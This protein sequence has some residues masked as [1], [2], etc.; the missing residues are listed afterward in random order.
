MNCCS[1]RNWAGRSENGSSFIRFR[2]A[3]KLQTLPTCL[4]RHLSW[5]QL[6]EFVS[7]STCLLWWSFCY[8]AWPAC[9][10]LS[11]SFEEIRF[12]HC[13]ACMY[14]KAMKKCKSMKFKSTV[15]QLIVVFFSRN[16]IWS[17][18]QNTVK[19]VI[20]VYNL[21]C[22]NERRKWTTFSQGELHKS[23]NGLISSQ[24]KLLFVLNCKEALKNSQ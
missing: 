22:W 21:Y 9:S 16:K 3:I 6:W 14:S 20:V 15:K 7:M 24:A 11:C 13:R 18:M 2:P 5:Y 4:Y 8:F 19:Q 12:D 23:L 10:I 1:S 17:P